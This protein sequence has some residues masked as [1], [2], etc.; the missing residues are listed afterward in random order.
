MPRLAFSTVAVPDQT[1]G[2]IAEEAARWGYQGLELRTSGFGS[3]E[4]AC[5]PA[6][7]DPAKLRDVLDEHGLHAACIATG[8]GFDEPIRPPVIG[9][10]N[11]NERSIRR[12]KAGIEIAQA[13]GTPYVRVFGFD[14]GRENRHRGTSRIVERLN[15]AADAARHTCVKLV[16]ENAGS[17]NTSA[18]LLDLID[19]ARNPLIG[20]EYSIATAA[21]AGEDP[22]SGA[23]ALGHRLWIAK[24]KDLTADGTPC[25]PGDGVLPCRELVELLAS[26]GWSGWLV[27][28]YDAAWIPGIASAERV[29]PEAAKRIYQWMSAAAPAKKEPRAVVGV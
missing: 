19:R 7:T 29:L 5:D 26:S 16:V 17:F 21:K 25:L 20:A 28:E 18:D 13:L 10:I 22:V 6:L 2:R 14:I 1:L 8:V 27:F 23:A 11:D 15:L 3:R 9:R 24:I 4:F 12:A